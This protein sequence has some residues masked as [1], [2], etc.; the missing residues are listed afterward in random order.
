M[1]TFTHTTYIYNH[2]SL[3]HSRNRRCQLG[4]CACTGAINV[5]NVNLLHFSCL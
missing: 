5:A 1:F 3:T 2:E 4:L